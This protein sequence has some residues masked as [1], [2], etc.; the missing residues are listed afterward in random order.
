MFTTTTQ[1]LLAAFLLAGSSVYAGPALGDDGANGEEPVEAVD[2]F[3]AEAA[4]GDK[5]QVEVGNLGQVTITAKDT[6]I[7]M[8]L[9]ILSMQS[10]RNIIASRNVS[11]TVSAN[12][13]QVDF[14]EALDAILQPNGFGYQEKGN[15]IYVKTLEEIQAEQEANRKKVHKLV[16]L[17]YL[18]ASDA[19]AYVSPLLSS[20][21][22]ISVSAEV[23]AGFQPSMGDG[24]A[25]SN[26]HAETLI[27]RDYE[28]NV[29]Q[30]QGLIEELDIKPEQVLIESTILSVR[31]TEQNALGID[32]A[33]YGDIGIDDITTPLGVVDD[34]IAKEGAGGTPLDSGVGGAT[35]AGSTLGGQSGVK[36]GFLG[37]DA[38]LFIRALDS[39]NDTN[40]LASPKMLVLNRQK[41]ELLVGERLGYLSTTVTDTSETQTVEFLDVGVQLTARPFVSTDGRVRMEL[42]ASLSDG[43]TTRVVEGNVIPQ[44]TTQEVVTNVIMR[45]GQTIV[46]GGLFKEDTGSNISQV[47]GIGH[48]PGLGLLGKGQDDTVDRSEVVFLVKPT[49]M[50]D[51]PLGEMGDELHGRAIE[52]VVGARDQLLPWSRTKMTAAHMAKARKFLD[53]GND[54]KALWHVN[55]AL[56]LDPTMVDAMRLKQELTGKP[57]YYHDRSMLNNVVDS[58]IDAEA[59]AVAPEVMEEAEVMD[60]AMSDAVDAEAEAATAEADAE[61]SRVESQAEAAAI[62]AA[63]AAE[64][65]ADAEASEASGDAELEEAESTADADAAAED[66]APQAEAQ[67]AEAEMTGEAEALR[68]AQAAEFAQPAEPVWDEAESSQGATA[69]AF[70]PAEVE[71]EI[72]EDEMVIE[73]AEAQVSEV[74]VETVEAK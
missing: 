48:V 12:L 55:L 67:T 54:D 24:G 50:K 15:F 30:I 32:F 7:T 58:V 18:N 52:S 60:E 70:T 69:D 19:A 29:E 71:V 38:S 68:P 45:N 14:Y 4:P 33:V 1:R 5:P 36:L 63:L 59:D 51:Q 6:D 13:Y 47:P 16:R 10:K 21:G 9:R 8:V 57:I 27:I 46:L 74:Q 53:E 25:N 23:Q 2:L 62:E 11:G 20:D 26:A 49:I 61:Q 65:A 66:I 72:V 43:D 37:S 39:V 28:E 44:E 56:H 73:E 17:N 31:L 3:D 35:S 64:Q 40:V 22:T 41:A 42:R 34:L